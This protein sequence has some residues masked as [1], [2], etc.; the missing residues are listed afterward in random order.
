MRGILSAVAAYPGELARRTAAAWNQFWFTPADPTL[1][2]VIRFCTGL[3]LLYNHAVWGLAL[4]DFFGPDG[5]ISADLAEVTQRV[6]TAYSF[7]WLVPERYLWPAYLASMLVL[8]LFLIGFWT[9][10]TSALAL[11]VVISFAY[12]VP[13]ATF[14]LD[15]TTAILTFYLALGPSGTGFSVDWLFHRRRRGQA[16]SR[17]EAS[18]FANFT[19]R[20]IQVHMCIFY[21]FAGLAKL[22]G[23]SWWNG[24]AMWMTF[25]NLE[26]QSTD[27]TWLAWHPWVI[28][29]LTHF[30]VAIEMSFCVLVW[31][32]ILRPLVLTAMVLLHVGIGTCLGLWTFSLIMCIGCMSFLPPDA[33]GRLLS[34]PA[35][36][37]ETNESAVPRG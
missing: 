1:L 37:K 3:M 14:G 5:W 35:N 11:A 22:Q 9:R 13:E 2:G 29:F 19:L 31:V 32:P 34:R 25:A 26:Y 27:M 33:V 36:P 7:W 17:P 16:S 6:Q 12:R 18:S 8:V 24:E 4:A 15:K 23:M 21:L 28:D 10:I 20:L 30:S